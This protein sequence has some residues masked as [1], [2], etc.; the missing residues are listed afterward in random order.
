M[1]ESG[2]DTGKTACAHCNGNFFTN[3]L[4]NIQG[5]NVCA[6]CKPSFLQKLQEGGSMV[7]EYQY[8]G[9]WIR[10]VAKI[11]D[12][13]ILWLINFPI[14]LLFGIS[15][16]GPKPGVQLGT[17]I[18]CQIISYAIAITFTVFFLTTK[19]ATPGKMLVG[20]KVI[21]ADGTEKISIG[22]AVGRFFAEILSGLILAIGY[23]IAAFDSEKRALHDHIC[24]TRVV[25]K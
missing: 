4:V 21:N 22:K 7:G 25:K 12:G 16:M 23:L 6:E 8:G 11:I 15:P 1:S 13:I 3:D 20:L 17:I 2:Y 14:G 10:F 19:G 9:F 24:N 18:F 5:Y